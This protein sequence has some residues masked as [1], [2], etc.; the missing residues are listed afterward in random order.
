M[1]QAQELITK[2]RGFMAQAK[3]GISPPPLI[4]RHV[5]NCFMP[6]LHF[7][8]YKSSSEGSIRGAALAKINNPDQGSLTEGEGSVF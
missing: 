8:L 1:I 6:Y 2:G 4:R 5:V 3:K 7:S